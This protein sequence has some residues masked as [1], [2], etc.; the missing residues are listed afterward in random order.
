MLEH[1]FNN[2]ILND[3][4]YFDK[5]LFWMFCL[6]AINFDLQSKKK[7]VNLLKSFL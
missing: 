6:S 3:H 5:L 7:G 4:F 1:Y 2:L